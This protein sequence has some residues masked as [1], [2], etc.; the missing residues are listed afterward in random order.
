MVS[1]LLQLK[2][3]QTQM[4][5]RTLLL[6]NLY[7]LAGCGFSSGLYKEILEAQNYIDQRKFVKAAEVY[8]SIL[9]RKPS[10]NIKIKVN[11]HL[12]DIYSIY[13]NDYESSIRHYSEIIKIAN[14]PI[15]QV[16]TLEKIGK[17]YFENLKDYEESRKAYLKLFNFIPALKKSTLYQLRYAQSLFYLKKYT[18]SIKEF[19]III[20]TDLTSSS[21]EAYYFLGL[22]YFYKKEWSDANKYWFEYIKRETRKDK[23]TKTKFLI[24]NAFESSEKLKEAYNIYYSILGDYP[25]PKVIKNRLNSL[26]KRRVARKR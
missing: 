23:I 14:K 18:R 2:K 24:A 7:F 19:K 25:N 17:I 15:W 20:S 22:A 13:L 16:G 1:Q 21:L 4:K 10:P 11:D 6:L 5:S 12:G 3:L 26:Y 8:E 9:L